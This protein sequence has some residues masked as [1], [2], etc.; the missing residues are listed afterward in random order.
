MANM[1]SASHFISVNFM[2]V[3]LIPVTLGFFLL[4]ARQGAVLF[5]NYC[6]V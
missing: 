2:V 6:V 3:K 5:E 1:F 4:K